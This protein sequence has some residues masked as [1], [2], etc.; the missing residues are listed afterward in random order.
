MFS[1]FLLLCFAL[2]QSHKNRFLYRFLCCWN[3]TCEF[4]NGSGQHI[5]PQYGKSAKK[6]DTDNPQKVHKSTIFLNDLRWGYWIKSTFP[7]T[8]NHRPLWT[9]YYHIPS[10]FS[11]RLLQRLAIDRLVQPRSENE[12]DLCTTSIPNRNEYMNWYNIIY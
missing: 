8:R 12:D 3:H 9:V 2:Y 1:W 7:N 6:V 4:V 10:I 11:N 5:C